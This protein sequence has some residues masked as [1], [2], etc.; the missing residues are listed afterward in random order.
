[1]NNSGSVVPRIL[2]R[3]SLS[4]EDLLVICDTMDLPPGV[5]RLKMRGSSAGQKGLH[6][7]ISVLGTGDFM[8]LYIGIGRPGAGAEGAGSA[9]EPGAGASGRGS[10][11][12]S[13]V[14]GVP[15]GGDALAIAGAVERAAG[16]VLRLLAVPPE[17]V[18]NE[19][20]A[21]ESNT[22]EINT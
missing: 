13:H 19:I 4:L 15:G 10:D 21:R 3:F 12:I 17:L 5:L 7:I 1:M 16:A 2:S 6:S 22:H 8:R 18:M 9:G 20:N 14:L 11:V